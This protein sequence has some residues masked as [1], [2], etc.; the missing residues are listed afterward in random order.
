MPTR[1]RSL[2]RTL[3][4][5][6]LSG[7]LLVLMPIAGWYGI[8]WWQ[9]RTETNTWTSELGPTGLAAAFPPRAEANLTTRRAQEL[10]LP[11]GVDLFAKRKLT[12]EV[13]AVVAFVA[14]EER[15]VEDDDR[16]VPAAVRAFLDA[17]S[18]RLVAV[19]TLLAESDLPTWLS[20][21]ELYYQ[22]PAPPAEGPR[23]LWALLLAHA[24][25]QD[26][27]GRPDAVRLALRAAGRLQAG[28]QQ[29]T[30]T[31]FEIL[32]ASAATARSGVRRRLRTEVGDAAG[33]TVGLR[34]QYLASYAA[35]ALVT[36]RY[37]QRHLV[38]LTDITLAEGAPRPTGLR[39]GV[40]RLLTAPY[41]RWCAVDHSRHVRT[42]VRVLASG[43]PCHVDPTALDT[44]SMSRV[45]RWSTLARIL[46][47]RAAARWSRVAEAE[48]AD[49]L[50]GVVV[51]TRRRPPDAPDVI[52]SRVCG[53]L[54]WHRLPDGAG[55][56][57]VTASGAARLPKRTSDAPWRYQVRPV[58]GG[59]PR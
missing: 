55:G 48:L 44:E 3:A 12:P 41:L 30:Q 37:Q 51:D 49:E 27:R 34:A 8:T 7:C 26:Q 42:L 22:E 33:T 20:D 36:T 10:V 58:R 56:V 9:L 17:H 38:S 6:Y 31:V 29:R 46:M 21:P 14:A 23:A 32:A 47:K 59:S 50:T 15:A 19:E 52:V 1:A 35:E 57:M 11:L 43:D 39:A 13:Q 2:A 54:E 28:L 5:V 40:E 16:P 45:S 24:R 25:D 18:D 4:K 53:G